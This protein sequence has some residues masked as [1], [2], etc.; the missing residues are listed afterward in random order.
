MKENDVVYLPM[1][2]GY[3]DSNG[4]MRSLADKRPE[5]NTTG[6][7]EIDYCKANGAGWQ[8][9]DWSNTAM[10]EDL[11]ML[12]GKTTDV[13]KKYGRGHDSGGSSAS[14]FLTTGTLKNKGEFWG[15]NSSDGS[16]AI[17]F[18]WLENYYADRWDRKQGMITNG[19][20]HI[21]VKMYPPYDVNGTG[22]IDTGIVPSGSSGSYIKTT[23]VSEYG[24]LPKTLNGSSDKYQPDG[25]WYSS[26]CFLLFGGFCGGGLV[27]GCAFDLDFGVGAAN[28]GLGGSPSFKKAS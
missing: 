21:C 26:G 1:F 6:T 27:C 16:K 20:T 4:K 22:Y 19:S 23:D 13:Q 9:D 14:S 2:K 28:W 3:V 17:K 7:Q 8:L 10:V 24:N 11:L 12:L 5:S 25:C 18:F 15:A